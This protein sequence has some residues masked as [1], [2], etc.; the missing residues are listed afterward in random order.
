MTASTQLKDGYVSWRKRAHTC[1]SARLVVKDVVT[2]NFF[3]IRLKV[4]CDRVY[5]NGCYITRRAEQTACRQ[6]WSAVGGAQ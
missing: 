6:P 2:A 3:V 1:A 4:I 5:V